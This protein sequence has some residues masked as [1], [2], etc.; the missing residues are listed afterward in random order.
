[1][2]TLMTPRFDDEHGF[3]LVEMMVAVM[4][5]GI[6][7]AAM[8]SVI[9]TSLTAVQRDEYRVRA[10]QLGQEELERL[11]ALEWDCVAFDPGDSDYIATYNGNETVDLDPAAC[12]DPSIAPD[13]SPTVITVDGI[14]YTVVPHVYWIDDPEDDPATGSDPAP[15][16]FK[17]FHVAVSWTLR[18][19]NYSYENTTTRVPT[20][21]E[22]PLEAA[23]AAAGFEIVSAEVDPVLVNTSSADGTDQP[24]TVTVETSLEATIVTLTVAPPSTYGAVNLSDISGDGTR[25]QVT[26]P[27]GNKT[28]PVGDHEFLIAAT[29]GLGADTA[30]ETVTFAETVVSPVTVKTP[31]LLPPAPICVANNSKSHKS[32]TVTVDIDGVSLVDQVQMSWT[33]KSGSTT[34]VPSGLTATGARFTGAIPLGHQFQNATTTLTVQARRLSDNSVAT[35]SYVIS[36]AQHNDVLNCP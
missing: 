32:V 8:A 33:D 20:V 14:D 27:A 28:F 5:L 9:I 12:S 24:I 36:I 26:I 23:S 16:D 2:H 13:P 31:I 18:G 35:G 6:I 1:M 21:E 11:R 7:L 3:T 17:E 15:H 10:T 4:L 34:G 25:W 22:V 19:T 30:S 29:G